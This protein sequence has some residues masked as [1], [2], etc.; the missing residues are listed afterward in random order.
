MWNFYVEFLIRRAK[1]PMISRL[2]ESKVAG[3]ILFS[4]LNACVMH[5]FVKKLSKNFWFTPLRVADVP[6][7]REDITNCERIHGKSN[8][9]DHWKKVK[10]I[11]F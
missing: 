8:C 2:R 4:V 6:E 9:V 3:A 11:E 1:S 10:Q 5:G 7:G